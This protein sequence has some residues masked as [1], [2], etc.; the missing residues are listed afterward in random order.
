M[1]SVVGD[2]DGDEGGRVVKVVD[3]FVIRRIA[4]DDGEGKRFVSG[5][6]PGVEAFAQVVDLRRDTHAQPHARL[7]HGDL[8]KRLRTH[9]QRVIFVV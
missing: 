1:V 7:V 3:G 2:G 9:L 6:S 8:K 4:R 5:R